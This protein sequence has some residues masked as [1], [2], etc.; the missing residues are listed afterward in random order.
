MAYL[1]KGLFGGQ[2]LSASRLQVRS[3]INTF[4]DL[5]GDVGDVGYILRS[6]LR[7]KGIHEEPTTVEAERL[8][9]DS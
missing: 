7:G 1:R 9:H 8:I 6:N 4:V 5:E 3:G 2:G